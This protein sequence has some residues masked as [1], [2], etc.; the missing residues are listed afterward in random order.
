MGVFL[1]RAWKGPLP[2][3]WVLVFSLTECASST[4]HSDW[5]GDCH[6]GALQ[7][8]TCYQSSYLWIISSLEKHIVC[9]KLLRQ[10]LKHGIVSGCR[11]LF[12][13]RFMHFWILESLIL[14]GIGCINLSDSL[15]TLTWYF[16]WL[17]N[18]GE[19][20]LFWTWRSRAPAPHLGR[21]CGGGLQLWICQPGTE[22]GSL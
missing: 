7:P 8:C 15:C 9:L 16:Y 6:R 10:N 14:V 20:V 17:Q 13:D 1:I 19:R 11:E 18:P 5:G 22:W 12:W 2:N 3:T 21:S 4:V